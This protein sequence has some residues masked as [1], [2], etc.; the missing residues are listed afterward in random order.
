MSFDQILVQLFQYYFIAEQLGRL[1]VHHQNVYFLLLVHLSLVTLVNSYRAPTIELSTLSG[2][3][4]YE[5]RKAAAR[6]SPVL[7]NIQMRRLPC[8]SRDLP[9]WLWPSEPQ[10]AADG[11]TDSA[12]LPASFRIHPS[13]AS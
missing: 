13:P 12:E 10:W 2:E 9:S 8:T 5:A 6:C 1:I 7:P 11:K 4:T 3:T